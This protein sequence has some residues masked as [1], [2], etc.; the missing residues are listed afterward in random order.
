M[1]KIWV[2]PVRTSSTRWFSNYK[3]NRHTL[4]SFSFVFSHVFLVL[5]FFFINH[6]LNIWA[7]AIIMMWGCQKKE[8]KEEKTSNE[9]RNRVIKTHCFHSTK[10]QFV[11]WQRLFL[12]IQGTALIGAEGT[13]TGHVTPQKTE[14]CD[15]SRAP[16]SLKRHAKCRAV[17]HQWMTDVLYIQGVNILLLHW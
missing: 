13:A 7:A 3:C 17:E 14:E 1:I 6:C 11:H 16:T 15:K 12:H 2:L 9:E 8:I 10:N 5:W 4:L